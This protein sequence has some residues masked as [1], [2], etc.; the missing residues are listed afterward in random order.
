MCIQKVDLGS[1]QVLQ[2]AYSIVCRCPDRVKDYDRWRGCGW[3][4]GGQ[5][6]SEVRVS[7]GVC[8]WSA[9]RFLSLFFAFCVR[10]LE[11]LYFRFESW[12]DGDL[13]VGGQ[14]CFLELDT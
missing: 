10:L 12:G 13:Q 5:R 2:T 3:K 11:F 14:I 7:S 6:S 4:G 8:V 9:G 1:Q